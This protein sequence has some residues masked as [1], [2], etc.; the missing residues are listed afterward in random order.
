MAVD[1]VLMEQAAKG[2]CILRF[3]RWQPAALSLGY[4]QRIDSEV[5]REECSKR[6]FDIVRRL[7]GGRGV[8]HHH[9]LTYSVACPEAVLPISVVES[10]RVLSEGLVA[11]LR[12]LGIPA[13]MASRPQPGM[14]GP[15]AA[16]FDTPSWYEITLAGKKLVGSAQ[17]R[18]QGAILQHGSLLLRRN[19]QDMAA[20][21][22]LPPE[23]SAQLQRVL[24]Q[25]S[26]ALGDL[27]YF[28]PWDE[29]T[30]ALTMGISGVTTR[31][32]MIDQ[33]TPQ[34]EERA[35]ELMVTK[36]ASPLWTDRR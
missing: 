17:T 7:T 2:Q 16:C 5:D 9:E 28:P 20:V 3:Y 31:V 27:G 36:Y 1:E 30:R 32:F 21:V 29:L 35:R 4:F 22:P 23:K 24:E 18:C 15:T 11:G 25:K 12:S 14:E 8:L 6:G 10:Y 34:E 19:T 13:E 26:C 33:L